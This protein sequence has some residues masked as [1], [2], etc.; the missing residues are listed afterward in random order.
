MDYDPNGVQRVARRVERRVEIVEPD[1]TWPE[2]FAI[3]SQRIHDALG[4][5]ALEVIHVGSTSIPGLPAKSVIDV[6][7]VVADPT[8]EERYVADLAAAGFQL[9]YREPAWFEHRFFGLDEPYANIH[10]FGPDCPEVSRHRIFREWL[11]DPEHQ[12]DF[13][14]YADIKREA[15]R[16]SQA[17]DETVIQYNLRKQPVIREILDRAFKAHGL[18]E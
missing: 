11:M 17:A 7:L 9:L 13:Q 6:D 8:K 2:S 4:D 1:P 16:A 12:D 15:S 5:R 18:M 10:C 14:K 3:I